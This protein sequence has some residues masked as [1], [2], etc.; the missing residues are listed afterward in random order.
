MSSGSSTSASSERTVDLVKVLKQ[1]FGVEEY[2][3]VNLL[4][5]GNVTIDGHC[6]QMPWARNHWTEAQLYGRMLK[7]PR[8]EARLFG[9]RLV[10]DNDQL[11][12]A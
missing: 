9:S 1:H 6:V 4:A 5:H 12:L 3:A 8:G 7:C 11:K 10:K 2:A